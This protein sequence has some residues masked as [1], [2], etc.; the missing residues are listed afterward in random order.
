MHFSDRKGGMSW[1]ANPWP[2][3][4]PGLRRSL[5]AGAASG[6]CNLGWVERAA[7]ILFNR[8]LVC[9]LLPLVNCRA[10]RGLVWLHIAKPKAPEFKWDVLSLSGFA[11]RRETCDGAFCAR[12]SSD[13]LRQPHTLGR[14]GLWMG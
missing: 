6:E 9:Y 4:G 1:R 8:I 2:T 3:M 10:Q 14:L 13:P 11:T 7:W 12:Q 5:A